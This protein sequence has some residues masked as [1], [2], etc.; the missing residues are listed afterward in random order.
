M[1]PAP[2]PVSAFDKPLFRSCVVVG[3]V[4]GL[5]MAALTANLRRWGW[6]VTDFDQLWFAGRALL[7]GA[8]PYTAW[9]EAGLKYPLYYPLH[10]VVLT[11]PLVLLPREVAWSALAGVTG[12]IAAYGLCRLGRWTVLGI[13]SPAWWGAA[14]MGQV[15]PALAGAATIPRLGFI[16]AAKPTVGL[17]LWISRPTK[18]AVTGAAV[19][20]L[21]CF[22]VRPD[23]G[24][25]WLT[26]IGDA[27]HIRAPITRPG[28]VLLLLSL[29]RW[30]TPEGR[31]LA[32]WALIP[33]TELLY[34]ALP[35]LLVATSATGAA[36]LTTC[37][38]LALVALALQPAPPADLV[39]REAATWP[40]ML[41][42]IYLPALFLV[43]SPLLEQAL[44]RFRMTR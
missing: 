41:G 30:R 17:A 39:A 6:Q 40:T 33:R 13:F 5:L 22:L 18:A 8:D 31:L 1:T 16:L 34:D 29:L 24:A 25:S 10:A 4:V 21:V 20:T 27:P 44:R 38:L 36:L 37:G 2:P 19:L 9:A 3:L 43:L 14:L 12:F 15:T 35:L 23:W 28:G 7:A 11:L 42:L 26:A 32:A